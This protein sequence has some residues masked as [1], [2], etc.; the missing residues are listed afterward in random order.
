MSDLQRVGPLAG[1]VGTAQPFTA[2]STAAQRVTDA[3]SRYWDSVKNGNV[4]LA[5][6]QAG[7]ALSNLSATCTGFCL[8][9][10][11]GSGTYLSLIE[12]GIVQT[13]TATTT[14]NAGIQ[15][16]ANVNP[17]AAVVVHTTPLTVRNALLGT[18]A[19][20]VGLADSASTLPAAP[21]AI[22]NLWQP[23]VSAT[24]TTAIPPVVIIPID[25]KIMLKEGTAISLS[26]LSALSVAA[27]MIWEEIKIT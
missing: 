26:S 12:I 16:A 15:L 14:A 3:H 7:A 21:V 11:A 4:W 1:A 25:G 13:S 23:S 17:V 20:P 2:D 6:N 22:M 19:S 24:A 5:A 18:S 8:T 10:P 27:H 9:N